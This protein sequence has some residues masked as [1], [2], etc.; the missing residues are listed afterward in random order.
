MAKK[1][2]ITLLSHARGVGKT[3]LAVSLSAMFSIERAVRLID[4]DSEANGSGPSFGWETPV[5][6]VTSVREHE[7]RRIVEL[8]DEP[9]IQL[10]LIDAPPFDS[11]ASRAI[12]ERSEVVIVP[13]SVSALDLPGTRQVL[14]A[15]LKLR[16]RSL[17][18]LSLVDARA[19]AALRKARESLTSLGVPLAR[20]PFCRRSVYQE[21]AA[22]HLPITVHAP[23]SIAV[24]EVRALAN[25]VATLLR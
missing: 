1:H 3:T 2:T 12:L 14:D 24:S 4:A 20:N 21:A 22:A 8:M 15:C 10:T 9:G 17:V 6:K 7:T 19:T 16:M 25:E 5:V 23:N 13:V 11:E 18:V